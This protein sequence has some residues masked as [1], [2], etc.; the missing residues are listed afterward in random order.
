MVEGG[1]W[2]RNISVYGR[3]VKRTWRVVDSFTRDP[4]GYVQEGSSDEH[5]SIGARWGTWKGAC[6]PGTMKDEWRVLE[7]GHLSPREL[8]KGNLEGGL[9]CW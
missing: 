1:L 8:Y 9:L 2:K 4:D 5:L 3:C 6:I 7:M